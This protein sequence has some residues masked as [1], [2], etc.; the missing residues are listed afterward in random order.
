M[1]KFKYGDRVKVKS[2]FYEGCIG[3]LES[4]QFD[5]RKGQCVYVVS[6]KPYIEMEEDNLE[7]D[8]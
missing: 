3:Y 1:A 4:Y 8:S 6:G 2:G 5:L 7:K